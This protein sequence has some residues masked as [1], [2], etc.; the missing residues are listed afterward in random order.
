MTFKL[1]SGLFDR[2]PSTFWIGGVSKDG[3]MPIP[4]RV[5]TTKFDK[6]VWPLMESFK[7]VSRIFE[8][9]T[10]TQDEEIERRFNER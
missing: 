9:R 7:N 8:E 1:F 6:G 5:D 2:E 3:G 4:L 10:R